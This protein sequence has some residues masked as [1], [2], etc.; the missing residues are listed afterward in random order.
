M[1][2]VGDDPI[3]PVLRTLCPRVCLRCETPLS[4]LPLQTACP[5]CGWPEDP[6][7]LLLRGWSTDTPRLLNAWDW[8]KLAWP[9][10]VVVGL[11]VALA[12]GTHTTWFAVAVGF[13]AVRLLPRWWR[14]RCDRPTRFQA[15]IL[16]FNS[17]EMTRRLP[18]R[19]WN[20]G[21]RLRFRGPNRRGRCSL[22]IRTGWA[23]RLRKGRFDSYASTLDFDATE[24]QMRALKSQLRAW[25]DG[26]ILEMGRGFEVVPREERCGL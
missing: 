19:L 22:T 10:L 14:G 15:S 1:H 21:W 12:R 6:G 2:G 18:L 9:L 17:S 23:I 20:L 3:D 16:G 5:M 8:M 13:F 25:R 7:I 11:A 4:D 24:E 26:V